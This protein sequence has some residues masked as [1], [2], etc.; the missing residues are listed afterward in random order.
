MPN[1]TEKE[2]LQD[3]LT[4]EKNL[5]GVYNTFSNECTNPELRNDFINILKNEHD[6]QADLFNEMQNKGWYE[7][8]PAKKTDID[9]TKQKFKPE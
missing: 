2:M 5:T 3:C 4:S 6:M 9:K 8:K 1:L 7:V